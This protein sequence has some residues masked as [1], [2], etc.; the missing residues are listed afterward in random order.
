MIKCRPHDE[1]QSTG[2]LSRRLIL[3]LARQW[4]ALIEDFRTAV[5]VFGRT[6]T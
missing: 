2:A 1:A 4:C 5:P 3:T 6:T